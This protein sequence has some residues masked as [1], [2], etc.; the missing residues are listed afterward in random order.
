MDQFLLN[1]CL[2]RALQ[3]LGALKRKV[4]N[5]LGTSLFDPTYQMKHPRNRTLLVNNAVLETDLEVRL[6]KHTLS[7][8]TCLHTAC[9]SPYYTA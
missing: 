8:T 3:V 9:T 4:T 1:I 7:P 5:T 2:R 6:P